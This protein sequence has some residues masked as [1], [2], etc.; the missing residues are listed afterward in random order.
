MF[1]TSGWSRESN[2]ARRA[3]MTTTRAANGDGQLENSAIALPEIACPTGVYYE[4]PPGV[5][6]PGRTGF[7]AYLETPQRPVNADTTPLP[8]DFEENWLEP[9]GSRGY[10]VDMNKNHVRDARPSITQ[11]WRRRTREGER[12]G[13]L[14]PE[15]VLTHDRYVS[16]VSRVASE[17]FD[18]RLLGESAM[19]HYIQAAIASDIGK[20][21]SAKAE[22]PFI[23]R[24]P[25]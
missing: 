22:S 23:G 20:G 2:L 6:R 12:Y 7:T 11:A 17:L 9:L 4:F 21:T 13:V 1:W 16:C 24:D 18:Q 8:P 19:L 10:L 15:E 3:P 25:R 5:S 14:G